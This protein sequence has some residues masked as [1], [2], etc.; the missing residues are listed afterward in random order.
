ME[1]YT[2]DHDFQ[3]FC[4]AAESFPDKV[5]EAHQQLHQLV[6]YSQQ[7]NYFGISRP[8]K[9]RIIYKAAADELEQGDLSKHGLEKFT[10]PKGKYISITIQNFMENIPA[11]GQAFEELTSY[12]GIDPQGY[13]IEW[14]LT[15]NDVKCMVRLK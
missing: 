13:C 15:G 9:G 4:I 7:R 1:H 8:E 14:Y 3:V 10:I 11:I 12:P 5:L 2:L 6:P